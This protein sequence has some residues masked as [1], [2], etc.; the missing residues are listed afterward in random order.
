[1]N[2]AIQH[3][4]LPGETLSE[5]FQ[6]AADY[7]FSG[8]EL[9]ASGFDGFIPD[10]VERIEAAVQQSG[11]PISSICSTGQDDFVHPDLTERNARLDRLAQMLAFADHV[12]AGGIVGLPIRN[13]QRLPDLS[14]VADENS[15]ITQLTVAILQL[16]L[17]RTPDTR[18]AIFLEPLNR[19]EARYLRTVSHAA[20]LCQAIG[21]PRV[22]V[23]ADLFHMSIEEVNSAEA[24]HDIQAYVGHVHLADSNRLLPGQ[25]HS[26]F[27][28]PFR[29]LQNSDFMGWMAL[30]CAIEGDPDTALPKAVKFIRQSWDQAQQG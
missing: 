18:S 11:V 2:L 3:R 30:E 24:L 21:S 1:M 19:Y 7:G 23:M 10:H 5:K 17:E 16:V 14:P 8:I 13:P 29:T 6:R 25:G 20:E 4:L 9:S 15:L 28:A 27:V 26:D 12:A 22:R